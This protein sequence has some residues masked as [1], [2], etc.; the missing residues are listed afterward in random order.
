MKNFAG[1]ERGDLANIYIFIYSTVHSSVGSALVVSFSFAARIRRLR[2]DDPQCPKM[3]HTQRQCCMSW[4]AQATRLA[5]IFLVFQPQCAGSPNIHLV[6]HVHSRIGH[7]SCHFITSVCNRLSVPNE[8]SIP[9][10]LIT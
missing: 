1:R 8:N 3:R 9:G 7:L 10:I 6:C 5:H 4:H 2:E